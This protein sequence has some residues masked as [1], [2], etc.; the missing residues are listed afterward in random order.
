M[1]D[2][3]CI[4]LKGDYDFSLEVTMVNVYTSY[5]KPPSFCVTKGDKLVVLLTYRQPETFICIYT[6]ISYFEFRLSVISRLTFRVGDYI[7][8]TN[9]RRRCSLNKFT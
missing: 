8:L 7:L 1:T 4:V 5:T 6:K 3:E 9:R 2:E